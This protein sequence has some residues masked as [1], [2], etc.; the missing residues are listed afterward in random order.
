MCGRY[1]LKDPEAALREFSDEEGLGLGPAFN[2]APT[3]VMPVV[4]S[5][6]KQVA[7]AWAF[8]PPQDQ[9]N[10]KAFGLINARA[11][12]AREKPAFRD[13]VKA[14][15]CAVIADGFYEWKKNAD[16]SKQAYFI[17]LK[18]EAP[19]AFAGVYTDAS[20]T[21]PPGYC[22]LTTAPNPIMAPIHDRMPVILTPE[23]AEVW[24]QKGELPKETYETTVT[25]FPT[26]AM[27]AWPVLPLVNSVR[28]DSPECCQPVSEIQGDLF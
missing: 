19:F 27:Q 2:V 7:M 13:A 3:Q 5:D 16:G 9:A 20:A 15:R 26:E 12:T 14:R 10:P 18:D 17:S 4:L 25:P 28:N 24:L 6:R 1:R 21:R 23:A 8:V 11:E 22:I